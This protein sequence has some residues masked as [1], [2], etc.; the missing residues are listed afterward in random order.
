MPEFKQDEF[1]RL[2]QQA[3]DDESVEKLEAQ[4]DA[5]FQRDI[6]RKEIGRPIFIQ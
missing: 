1:K 5:L 4:A 6:E 3:K 2:E